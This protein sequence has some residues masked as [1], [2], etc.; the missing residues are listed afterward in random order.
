VQWFLFAAMAVAF[1]VIVVARTG[2]A[3]RAP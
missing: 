3:G 1:A 2:G